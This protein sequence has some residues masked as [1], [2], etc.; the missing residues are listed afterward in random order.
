MT[1]R[2][3]TLFHFTK[4]IDVLKSIL[5]NGFWPQYC[6]ED[7]SWQGYPGY[8]D[9]AF[10]MS[11]FCDIPISKINDHVNFYGRYG[12]GLK[13]EWGIENHLNPVFYFT[14]NNKLYQ[15]MGVLSD[16]LYQVSDSEIRNKGMDS[17]RHFHSHAKCISGTVLNI[18]QDKKVEKDFLQ[19]SEWRYVPSDERIKQYLH[20][21]K[22]NDHDELHQCNQLTSK[23]CKLNIM[24]DDIRYIFVHNDSEIPDMINFIN[25]SYKNFPITDI[26]ILMTRVTSLESLLRDV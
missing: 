6:L 4:N 22:Y 8:D 2:S 7:V 18:Q 11:C 15:S 9:V 13:K 14:G 25:T 20:R 16:I 21:N 23:Y 1:T 12:V 24:P 19:E 17:I 5:Q 3:D 10:P 26:Q